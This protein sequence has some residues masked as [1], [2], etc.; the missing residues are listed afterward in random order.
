MIVLL[1]FGGYTLY[2]PWLLWSHP[3][4]NQWALGIDVS[5]VALSI[6]GLYWLCTRPRTNKRWHAALVGGL[7][8]CCFFFS[9]FGWLWLD[10]THTAW[11]YTQGDLSQHHL[12]WEIYRQEPFAWPLGRIDGLRHPVGSS[13]FFTDAMPLFALLLKPFD[14]LLPE[15]FQYQGILYLLNWILMGAS[16]AWFVFLCTQQRI[17]WLLSATMML[18]LPA[19]GMRFPHDTLT[20]QWLLVVSIGWL[21]E[22]NTSSVT[23]PPRMGR[24]LILIGLAT[25]THFYL[26]TMVLALATT[27]LL[28]AW[29]SD[30]CLSTK[31]LATHLLTMMLVVLVCMWLAGGLS[32]TPSHASDKLNAG[33]WSADALT[34]INPTWWSEWLPNTPIIKEQY[35]GAA[36]LGLGF[37]LMLGVLS[38]QYVRAKSTPWPLKHSQWLWG[39]CL[40][41]LI[42]SAGLMPATFGQTLADWSVLKPLKLH[43][44]FRACGRFAWMIHYAIALVTL[45]VLAQKKSKHA[46]WLLCLFAGIQLHDVQPVT[47]YLVSQKISTKKP[48]EPLYTHQVWDT[49]LKGK[50]H[51][52][53]VPAA[54]CPGKFIPWLPLTLL[55]S[56]HDVTINA[57]YVAR[58]NRRAWQDYCADQKV[59]PAETRADKQDTVFFV[60]DE[61]QHA[62]ADQDQFACT[63]LE[64]IRV[65]TPKP[66]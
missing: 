7:A 31:K 46:V 33:R 49:V 39:I 26:C 54:G 34:L 25:L 63:M 62:F 48:K 40:A 60:S 6:I 38:I 61:Q 12:A 32:I 53:L 2:W 47:R 4:A 42:F 64:G 21:I 16:T 14:A 17:V 44:I 35:E 36:Y 57:G 51:I 13:L 58:I 56:E 22:R 3:Q 29:V 65:C 55:A 27:D 28:K 66:D 9:T 24:W 41:A 15:P 52:E 5:A 45:M 10:P 59:E 37:L 30:Q 19:L 43:G 18:S 1:L 20:T 23:A 8:G 11:L 50:K